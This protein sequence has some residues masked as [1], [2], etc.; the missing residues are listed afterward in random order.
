VRDTKLNRLRSPFGW[1][2]IQLSQLLHYWPKI[3][4]Y[5]GGS[6]LGIVNIYSQ[7][8]FTKA[9]RDAG[10]ETG[11]MNAITILPYLCRQL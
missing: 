10:E 7:T 6:S 4:Y 9:T 8:V 2:A 5:D 11:L 1:H 3:S